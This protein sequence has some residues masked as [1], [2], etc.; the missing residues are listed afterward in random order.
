MSQ[1]K[2]QNAVTWTILKI[3]LKEQ[4]GNYASKSKGPVQFIIIFINLHYTTP[5]QGIELEDAPIC[6]GI[7]A[8]SLV[9]AHCIH[10]TTKQSVAFFFFSGFLTPHIWTQFFS[11][12]WLWS[13]SR[14]H[15]FVFQCGFHSLVWPW[16]MHLWVHTWKWGQDGL[17]ACVLDKIYVE[18]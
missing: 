12:L 1:N 4:S 7:H 14:D 18:T 8:I 10:Q 17:N 9:L 15:G 2:G 13:W 6:A 5:Q 11:L 16:V 3:I